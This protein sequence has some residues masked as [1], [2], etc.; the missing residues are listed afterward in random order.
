MLI[1]RFVSFLVRPFVRI[2]NW[3]WETRLCGNVLCNH[4]RKEHFSY[5]GFCQVGEYRPDVKLCRCKAYV[6]PRHPRR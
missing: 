6:S 3:R 2:S 1:G 5:A 4:M